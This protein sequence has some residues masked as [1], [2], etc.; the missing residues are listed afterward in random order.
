MKTG[1]AVI[2]IDGPFGYGVTLNRA[3]PVM[4]QESPPWYTLDAAFAAKFNSR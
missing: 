1:S 2:R 4:S 3:L